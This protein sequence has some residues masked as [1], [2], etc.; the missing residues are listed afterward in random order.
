[1]ATVFTK[2]SNRPLHGADRVAALL[3]TMGKPAAA[4]VMKHFESEDIRL[5][6]RAIAEMRPV[7]TAQIETVVEDFAAQFVI[8]AN[9]VGSATDAERLL[10]GIIPPDQINAIMNDL[11]GSANSSIWDRISGIPETTIATYVMKEHPQIA[12]LIL[13]KVK[14]SC[15][16]KV[17]AHLPESARNGILRRM[18][19]FKPIVDETMRIIENTIHEDFMINLARNAG[20]DTHVR[21]A[22]IINKM[23]RDDMEKVLGS[24][25]QTRPKSAEILTSLLFTFED[26]VKLQPRARTALFDKVP[27]DKAVIALKGTDPDFREILLQSLGSRVRRMVEQELSIGEPSS[28]K[29]VLEARRTITDLALEMANRGEIELNTGGDDDAFMR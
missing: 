15:A 12:A 7:T 20:A 16:A 9:D 5:V 3:M 21:I 19:A 8:G 18:L 23:E 27:T 4:R 10:D 25:A 6:T 2:S 14:P 1:M 13:N 24:L 29:D 26:L 17:M 22:D 28:Q 11:A